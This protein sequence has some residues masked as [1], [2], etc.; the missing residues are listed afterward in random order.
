MEPLTHPQ[1][2]VVNTN[3]VLKGKVADLELQPNDIVYI[4]AR[5]WKFAE[6]LL[7]TAIAAFSTAAITSYTGT[8]VPQ[9]IRRPIL[10]QTNVNSP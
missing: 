1:T 10:P 2:I 9:I 5:P 7:D 8:N 4:S 6:E 3:D